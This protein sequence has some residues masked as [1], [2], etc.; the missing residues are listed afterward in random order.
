MGGV[1][2]GRGGE[3]RS[4]S[5]YRSV[6]TG[7]PAS[8]KPTFNTVVLRVFDTP[9]ATPS[10]NATH[11]KRRTKKGTLTGYCLFSTSTFILSHGVLNKTH[12]KSTKAGWKRRGYSC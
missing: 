2:V 1:Q 3:G 6:N 12:T 8:P 5:E 7:H 4:V 9:N 11:A 10:H